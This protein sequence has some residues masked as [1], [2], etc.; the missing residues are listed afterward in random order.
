VNVMMECERALGQERG[1]QAC[2]MIEAAI[3]GTCPCKMGR[4]CPLLGGGVLIAVTIPLRPC[5]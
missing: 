3:G 4:V 5:G 2:A 1:E